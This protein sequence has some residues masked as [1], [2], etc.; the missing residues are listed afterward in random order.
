MLYKQKYSV[1]ASKYADDVRG[2]AKRLADTDDAVMTLTKK[3]MREADTDFSGDISLE[4]FK[5]AFSPII[6]SQDVA[7]LFKAYDSNSN[8]KLNF[9]ELG[10]V[11]GRLLAAKVSDYTL[12]KL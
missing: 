4:E 8:G 1:G 2:L 6:G 10:H 5:A 9:Q 7:A 3:F 11:T 12:P